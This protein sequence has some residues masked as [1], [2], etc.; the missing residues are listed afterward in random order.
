MSTASNETMGRSI[1]YLRGLYRLLLQGVPARWRPIETAP[2]DGTWVD[3]WCVP[4]N[5]APPGRCTNASWE[6]GAWRDPSIYSDGTPGDEIEMD[7]S[8]WML[9]PAPPTVDRAQAPNHG[10]G[11]QVST[12]SDARGTTGTQAQCTDMAAPR[13]TG[14]KA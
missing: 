6:A 12:P 5:G 4:R 11:H 1:Q 7:P 10:S 13:D 14:S 2:K 8:H 9:L 3:L